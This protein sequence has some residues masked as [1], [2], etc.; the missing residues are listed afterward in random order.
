MSTDERFSRF[1]V[2][3]KLG[4]GGTADVAKVFDT[5]L[6]RLAALKTPLAENVVDFPGLV[7]REWDMIGNCR[8]PGVVRLLDIETDSDPFLLMEL[9][10]G[11]T[12][13]S[14][15]PARNIKTALNLLS[16][17]AVDLEFL[18]AAGIIHGDVKAQ[19]FFLPK[20][21][22]VFEGSSLFYVKLSDFSLGRNETE[23]DSARAGLGTVGYMAPETIV[24]GKVSH[25]SDLFAFGALAYQMLT[26]VHPF[27]GDDPEPVRVNARVI[28]E[29]P[30]AIESIR[31]D[32]PAELAA[33]INALL[34]K[35][36]SDRPSSAWEVCLALEEY[37]ATYPFRRALHPKHLIRTSHDFTAAVASTLRLK[38]E[39]PLQIAHI[40]DKR[41]NR[42]RPLLAANFNRG[43]LA[44]NDGKFEFSRPMIHP[45]R[46]RRRILAEFS[47]AS[48][49]AKRIAVRNSI[50]ESP[51][52]L[53][54][55]PAHR[56][57][58]T[59][60]LADITTDLL[61]PL[62][63]QSTIKRVATKRAILF[64]RDNSYTVAAHLYLKAG[65]LE[66][67]ERCAYQAACQFRKDHALDDAL[68][69][70]Q[71]IIRFAELK[72]DLFSIR[73]LIMLKG[74]ILKESGN[75][76]GAQETYRLLISLYEGQKADSLLGE[77]H[78]DLGDLAKMQQDFSS[79]IAALHQAMVIFEKLGDQL[80]V[81]H[82]LNNLGNIHWIASDLSRARTYYLQA[83][84]IQRKLLSQQDIASTLSNLGAISVSTGSYKRSLRLLRLALQLKEEIGNLTEIARTLN[85][86][87]YVSYLAGQMSQAVD[88]LKQ[89]LERNRRT[90]NKHEILINLGNL[91]LVTFAAGRL[92]QTLRYVDEGLALAQELHDRPHVAFFKT[93]L[94]DIL[95]KMGRFA[96]AEE[97]F[98]ES[99]TI[100]DELDERRR[101]IEFSLQRANLRHR[102]GDTDQ[103][104]A[105][106]S[107]ALEEASKIKEANLQLSAMV[108]L[109]RYPEYAEHDT[110]AIAL[111]TDLHLNRELIKLRFNTIERAL[112]D[113]SSEISSTQLE[114]LI[115][116]CEM[117]DD[118]VELPE[119]CNLA[120]EVLF[121][122]GQIDRASRLVE[123]SLRLAKQ[124]ELLPE[125]AEANCLKGQIEARRGMYE[126]AYALSRQA[127]QIVKQIA[128]NI[129][130]DSDRTLYMQKRWVQTMMGEIRRL[131]SLLGQKQRAGS[132]PA[133]IQS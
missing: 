46:L 23:D 29:N 128:E 126:S 112:V 25:K 121:R 119:M 48:S 58:T 31:P 131:G 64:E 39:E 30:P 49:T 89:S 14:I 5:K 11:K 70:C 44:Y 107:A 66:S 6:G 19:N 125:L 40:A 102:I 26:G 124:M 22:S 7:R 9:C 60:G 59:S 42:L 104:A 51:I 56:P 32:I 47:T 96:E 24:D 92:R 4:R 50:I 118:N 98:T 20:D 27:I 127:L 17:V 81:S 113:G 77:A 63:R 35:S 33:L 67:A 130:T 43:T 82:V 8:F 10:S 12:L 93:T 28:E 103:A 100:L 85:N 80:E 122:S 90:S 38:S 15:L 34:A 88:Y 115:A 69:L 99:Q 91:A 55:R 87:G 109:T 13:D 73:A 94:G 111:A 129:D 83:L 114:P 52:R 133:L 95:G 72:N 37:G 123:K 120:A 3:D 110:R 74:D 21:E 57:A 18:R 116:A 1:R 2:Q 79:G 75:A 53:V 45:E 78:K 54:Q 84:K 16:A 101:T 132:N 61:L 68:S 117:S 36:E 106:A 97:L 71:A 108:S 105:I 65:D 76:N 86:L 62:L 41:M